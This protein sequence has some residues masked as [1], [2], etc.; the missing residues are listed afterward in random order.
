[1]VGFSC[2]LLVIILMN[3]SNRYAFPAAFLGGVWAMLPD[4]VWIEAIPRKY[5][6]VLMGF[7]DSPYADLCFFHKFF[8]GLYPYDIPDDAVIYI[9]IGFIVT[10]IYSLYTRHN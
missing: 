10:T 5:T 6:P 4:L 2:I 1:M 3:H 9:V 7:H 8:D